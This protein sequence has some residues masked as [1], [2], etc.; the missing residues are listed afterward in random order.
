MG[1]GVSVGGGGSGLGLASVKVGD[2]PREDADKAGSSVLGEALAGGSGPEE[3]GGMTITI[4][5]GKA[6]YQLA[7]VL[8]DRTVLDIKRRLEPLTGV[9]FIRQKLVFKGILRDADLIGSTKVVEG[10]K[11]MLLGAAAAKK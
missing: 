8:P 4:G 10:V 2:A 1:D 5:H 7:G 9:P 6:V 3:E 11:V